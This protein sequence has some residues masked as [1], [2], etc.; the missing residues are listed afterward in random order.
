M[1]EAGRGQQVHEH[2]LSLPNLLTYGRIAAAPLVGATFFVEGNAGHWMAFTI[3]ALASITDY[4]DG[5]L[6][7]AWEQQSVLGRMLDPIADKLL[8]AVS[9]LVLVANGM[10]AGLSIWAAIIVLM[11]EIFVSGLREFLAE[12][13]VSVPVTKLA[14]WKT[15]MQLVAIAA[16]LVAPALQ[17][18]KS[19]YIIDLGLTF[20]W[21]A[22]IVT[23]YT[24]YDYFRA[25]LRHIV[26]E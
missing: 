8:V 21:A 14:K 2:A 7:R 6:A 17:G 23:L 10:L 1:Q 5:Y 12:L 25:G 4:V 22:A 26:Q 16:L 9:I 11:R 20:F 18:A 3:F 15:T 24:G 13:R 19:G